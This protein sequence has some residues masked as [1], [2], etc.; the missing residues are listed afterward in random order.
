MLYYHIDR[1]GSL[2][3]NTTLNAESGMSEHGIQ[4]WGD[5]HVED[6]KV[7]KSY[8]IE[9][10]FEEVRLAEFP[11]KPSRF[12]SFFACTKDTIRPWIDFFG[13]ASPIYEVCSPVPA[14]KADSAL[15]NAFWY[16][17]DGCWFDPGR[18]RIQARLYWSGRSIRDLYE[19]YPVP[20]NIPPRW[21]YLLAFPVKILR[22]ADPSEFQ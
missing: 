16:Y 7:F 9:H 2:Q 21:E 3:P 12:A 10:L 1:R 20:K 11:T 22:R 5:V 4:Y 17:P 15:L 18:A 8:V 14:L 19:V 13:T 6:F